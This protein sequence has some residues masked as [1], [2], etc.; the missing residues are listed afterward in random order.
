MDLSK[1]IKDR[2]LIDQAKALA[3]EGLLTYQPFVFSPDFEVG[4]GYEFEADSYVGLVYYP[5]ID[6]NLLKSPQL[7]RL[8]V[9]PDNY[10]PYHAANRRLAADYDYLV[11]RIS[12]A[13]GGAA[14]NTFLDVGCN[15]GYFPQSFAQRGAK[16]AAGCD[17]QDFSRTFSLPNAINGRDVSYLAA[18]YEPSRHTIEGLEPFDVVTS[19]AMVCHVAD[20]LHLLSAMGKLARK[21]IF[22]WT[23]INDDDGNTCHYGNPRGDYP[24]DSFPIVSTT[25]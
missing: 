10:A 16:I 12:D 25:R 8:I 17:R 18:W 15:V 7:S 6:A 13:V 9:S 5:D 1:K 19:L 21:A 2:A 24:G 4:V 23:L 22:V 3:V 20:P 11:D 14:G